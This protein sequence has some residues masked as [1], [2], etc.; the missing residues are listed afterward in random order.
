M[1]GNLVPKT[2][3]EQLAEQLYQLQKNHIKKM[4]LGNHAQQLQ[5]QFLQHSFKLADHITLNQVIDLEQLT[6]V[7]NEQ[8]FKINLAPPMLGAIG[9]IAQSIHQ[10]LHTNS[11]PLSS[12]ISDHQVDHWL[13]KILEMDHI[14]EYIRYRIEHT[15]QFRTL[16]AY[17]I[18]QNIEYY[19]P[20]SVVAFA[21]KA[22]AKL[23][24]RLQ[25]FLH[26]QQQKIEEKIEEKAA[27]LFQK[28]VLFLFSLPKDE[29]LTIGLM[30]W[31]KIKHKS[32]SEFTAHSSPLD[33]EELFIL[34]YEFWKDLRQNSSVQDIIQTCIEQFYHSFEHESLFY[35]FQ[36]TGLK[37]EDIEVEAQRFAPAI[38]QRLDKLNLLDSMIE[39]FVQPFFK[40]SDTLNLLQSALDSE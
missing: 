31:E 5:Q 2:T 17:W 32:I 30:I 35:L 27:Q 33:S 11:A 6:G 37:I 21:D 26:L 7:V 12:F 38:L 40:K 10:Q 1:D 25:N 39:Y 15:P 24:V 22:T 13:R 29:Y 18:N 8:V 19:T 34:I 28:Q 14:F 16:C 23:S 9:E 20:E 3:P 4:L 36:A